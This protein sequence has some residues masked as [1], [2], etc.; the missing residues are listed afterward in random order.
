MPPYVVFVSIFRS[1]RAAR[2]ISG[3]CALPQKMFAKQ[4]QINSSFSNVT[5]ML[6]VKTTLRKSQ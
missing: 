4:N 2:R 1:W 5:I 3:T 6:K